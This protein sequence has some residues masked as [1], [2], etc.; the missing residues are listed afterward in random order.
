MRWEVSLGG[1]LAGGLAKSLGLPSSGVPVFVRRVIGTSLA[2]GLVC[3]VVRIPLERRAFLLYVAR[4]L[5][6]G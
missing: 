2:F 3:A 4:F 5:R 6:V 1:V